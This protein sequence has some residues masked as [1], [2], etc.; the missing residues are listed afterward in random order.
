MSAPV[1]KAYRKKQQY[2]WALI[3]SILLV[4]SAVALAE[5]N[6][7]LPN[8]AN[9]AVMG[10]GSKLAI[11][12][13]KIVIEGSPEQKKLYRYMAERLIRMQPGDNLSAV[14]VQASIDALKLSH[15]FAAIHV[16]SVPEQ[17]GERVIF[18]LTPYRTIAEIDIQ[19]KYPLFE[20][21]ILN[22]MT[23][24][25]GNPWTPEQLATQ[26]EGVIQLY[27]RAGYIDPKVSIT[28]QR[29]S[30]DEK[31]VVLVDIDKG[32]HYVL[33]TLVFQGN[34]N[35]SATAL[36]LRMSV[37][38]ADLMPWFSK[39]SEYQLKKDMASLLGYY[40]K[41]GFVD[42]ELAYRIDH[43]GSSPQLNV[44]V[45]ISEGPHYTVDFAG[46]EEFW[47]ITLEKDVVLFTAGNKNNGGIRKSI[48][49]I[50]KRYHDKGYLETGIKAEKC[51]AADLTAEE[52][53]L[54][55]AIEE[56]PQTLVDQVT[57]AG[58]KAFS[59]EQI[60]EQLL[61]RPPSILHNGAFVPDT[62]ETD[63]YAVTTLYLKHGFDQRSVDS[64][65]TF[66]GD[67][68][69]ADIVVDIKEG[70]QT[71]VRSIVLQGLTVVPEAEAEKVLVHHLGEPF[72]TAASDVEK[73]AL[74]GLISEKGYPHATVQANISYS[75]DHTLADIVYEIDEGA[76]VI[77]GDIFV[78]GNLRTAEKVIEKELAV[79][80]QTPL[81]LQ[82]LADGQRRLRDMEIFHGVN[83][84]TF[85]L[86]EK[87]DTVDLF[88]EVE[89]RKPYYI[90][91]GGGYQSD[92]GFFGRIKGGDR[93]LFG[94]NKG[95]WAAGEVSETGYRLETQLTEPRFL[96]T[97]IIASVGIF[98]EELTEFNQP[99]GTRTTGSSLGFAHIWGGELTTNLSLVL[100]RRNQFSVEDRSA[101]DFDKETRTIIVT[102]PSIGYDTRD[103]FVRPTK[104]LLSSL[105]VDV[106]K[107][108]EN[109]LDDFVRY[110]FDTRYYWT[111]LKKVTFAGMAR[112]GQVI[113]YSESEDVPDD[114]LFYLGGIQSVRGFDENLLRFDG[115]G[116]PAG[117]KT[118]VVGSLEARIDLGMNMELAT[119]LDIGRVQDTPLDEGPDG[120]RSS[121]GIGLRY[122]TPIGPIGLVYGHKLDPD[123]GESAGRLHFSIG[124]SF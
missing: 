45:E 73:E 85:G 50:K 4:V 98:A 14:G 82:A 62:L 2:L 122:I 119:F 11:S 71:R 65:V 41:K 108:A 60:K 67:K 20:Q 59:E 78:S 99:F 89:E 12:T 86:K 90:Q 103:S 69:G 37:W 36:K 123:E 124:Y 76:Q 94:L 32:P 43:S 109:E 107:G 51:V 88:V 30:D 105:G 80:P 92:T 100:E 23:I 118:A 102:T 24:Y 27:K 10:D 19:G 121:V 6:I 104:G 22:Q 35:V 64:R 68:T 57:I 101:E 5:D 38:R 25:P 87:A 26:V 47:D 95:L 111:P 31:V 63:T 34:H 42:A 48:Q 7:T 8:V 44:I 72:R 40:R 93:N 33:G 120:F 17:D 29:R 49:N 21:D 28:E 55:F 16:D 77:L 66:S 52:Y 114:Q 83:Y 84:R 18:T 79:E 110:H 96:G 46:N 61:T 117:G 74:A 97:R 91:G 15:R 115:K 56:G 9:S 112:I 58:N 116:D 81:S 54:C 39:F 1:R 113:S 3:F 13:V 106:S 70:P 75:E 53:P